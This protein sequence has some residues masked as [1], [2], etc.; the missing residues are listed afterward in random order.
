MTQFNNLTLTA[1]TNSRCPKVTG[2]LLPDSM[3]S[4]TT[5]D[6]D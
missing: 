5:E 1:N 2:Y 4:L 6:L 3:G